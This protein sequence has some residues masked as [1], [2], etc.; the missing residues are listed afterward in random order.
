[1]IFFS[2]FAALGYSAIVL[3]VTFVFIAAFIFGASGLARGPLWAKVAFIVVA[4]TLF[5]PSTIFLADQR[6]M[7]MDSIRDEGGLKRIDTPKPEPEST[8]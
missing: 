8:N 3:V 2:S 5:V 6:G 4:I 1:M 7:L